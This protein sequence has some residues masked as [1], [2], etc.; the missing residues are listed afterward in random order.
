MDLPWR[1]NGL[2][3]IKSIQMNLFVLVQLDQ[4]FNFL[5]DLNFWY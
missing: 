1:F 5:V 4:H 3:S 2:D